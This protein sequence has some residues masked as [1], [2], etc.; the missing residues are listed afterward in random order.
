[1]TPNVFP[2][3]SLPLS[4]PFTLT[5]IVR[6][7]TVCVKEKEFIGL[8]HNSQTLLYISS[9]LVFFRIRTITHIPFYPRCVHIFNLKILKLSTYNLV[10]VLTSCIKFYTKKK[11]K[12]EQEMTLLVPSILTSK[13]SVIVL[14]SLIYYFSH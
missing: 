9:L 8:L 2:Q 14:L 12:K 13:I 11:K 1:M 7:K 5:Y 4:P 3:F 10:I 6:R